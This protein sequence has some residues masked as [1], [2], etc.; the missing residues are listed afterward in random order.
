MAYNIDMQLKRKQFTALFVL[1]SL[2]TLT[3]GLCYGDDASAYMDDSTTSMHISADGCNVSEAE[4]VQPKNVQTEKNIPIS[5]TVLPCCVDR[6]NNVSILQAS[7]IKDK[8]NFSDISA[9]PTAEIIVPVIER[10]TY[11]S[12]VSPPPKPDILSS[13]VKIE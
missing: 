7:E 9:I 10:K 12:S 13:V 4:P 2:I 8:T 5:D 3:S 1:I 11:I 6:H